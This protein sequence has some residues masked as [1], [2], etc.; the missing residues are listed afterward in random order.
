MAKMID[1]IEE[2][3]NIIQ[4]LFSYGKVSQTLINE[5]HIYK[6]YQKLEDVQSKMMKYSIISD[7]LRI[8]DKSVIR[9]VN[10]MEKEVD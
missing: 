5:Y 3:Y 6:E 7:M 8:S 9:A 4:T 2:N 10:N 1:F